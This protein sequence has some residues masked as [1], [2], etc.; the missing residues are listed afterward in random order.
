MATERDRHRSPAVVAALGLVAVAL[1]A[2]G[3]V[4]AAALLP[5][6]V[7]DSLAAAVGGRSIVVTAESYDGAHAVAAT[8]QLGA[9]QVLRVAAS[10]RLAATTC[11]PGV[12]IASGSA[13]LT[14][15]GQPILALA[16]ARPPVRDLGLRDSGPDVLALQQ[17]LVR[18]GHDVATSGTYDVPTRNAVRALLAAAGVVK[19]AG[20]LPLG[21]VLWLPAPTVTVAS[22]GV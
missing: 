8:A 17:E 12:A 2:V 14:V 4:G 20:T 7:P 1:A 21:S 15:D 16:T 18:V 19:P 3:V 11:A 6:P 5:E 13:P 9:Q 10:G 22:C